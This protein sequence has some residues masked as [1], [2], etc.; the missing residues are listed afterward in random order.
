MLHKDGP[1][2]K[3]VIWDMDG[4]IA[5]TAQYHFRSWQE[6]FGK[7]GVKFTEEQFRQHFGQR[8][9]HIIKKTLGEEISPPEIDAIAA[10]KEKG[11]RGRIA[12]AQ[13]LKPLPGVLALMSALQEHQFKMAL[14]SSG[15]WENIR[16]LVRTLGIGDYFRVIVAGRDVTESKPSPQIFLLAAEKLGVAP[17]NCI[18]IED[19]VAGVTGAK[20]AGMYCLAVTTTHPR[21]NLAAA[22][23][24]VDT[25]TR[26]SVS[27]L[28]NLF[29]SSL[30]QA[31]EK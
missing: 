14:A 17:V 27:D 25:L 23:I 2:N 11:F 8:N 31:K 26:V 22:D 13:N 12:Q 30:K 9:D 10:E 29:V 18:V 19:S 7:R 20:R 3:A 16:L 24:I 6:V 4:V 15:P 5:D 1:Q 21:G 28:E